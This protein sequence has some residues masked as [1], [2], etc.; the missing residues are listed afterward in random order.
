MIPRR[1]RPCLATLLALW[2]CLGF[3]A[4]Q[5][6]SVNDTARATSA[7]ERPRIGLVLS[8]GGARGLAHVGVLKVLEENHIPVDLV[9]GTSAG[10]IIGGLYA[11]G[12]SAREIEQVVL[13]V[14][15]NEGFSDASERQYRSFNRK[16]YDLSILT[17]LDVGIGLDGLR[18]PK[19]LLQGQRLEMLLKKV[20]APAELIEDFDRLPVPFR[21]V[22]TDIENGERVV[23]GHGSIVRAIHA[24]MAIPG[25][26]APVE[27]GGRMLV[28]GGLSSNLPVSTARELGANHIIAI[29]IST[30]LGSAEDLTSILSVAGQVSSLLTQRTVEQEISRLQADDT[31]ITPDLKGY[32]SGDF[33]KAA[34]IIAIGEQAARDSLERL[35]RYRIDARDYRA[36]RRNKPQL[37]PPSPIIDELVISTNSRIS[38]ARLASYIELKPGDRF[39]R[40]Q[41]E[42]DIANLYGLGYFS[43]ISYQ[44]DEEDG[45]TSLQ[46]D[47]RKKPWGPNYL[48]AGLALQGNLSGDNRVDIAAGLLATEVN[49]LG[50]EWRTDAT[51]GEHSGVETEFFQPLSANSNSFVAGTL[52]VQARNVRI[53]DDGIAI[54][55]A[56][57]KERIAEFDIGHQ[58]GNTTEIRLGVMRASGTAEV[59]TGLPVG[60]VESNEGAYQLS[61]RHDTMDNIHFPRKGD[62]AQLVF[63]LS[64]TQLGADDDNDLGSLSLYKP[65]T[66]GSHTLLARLAYSDTLDQEKASL[67]QLFQIGGFLNLS[68]YE[69]DELSGAYTGLM[70][71][72]YYRRFNEYFIKNAEIP[73]FIGISLEGGNA[74]LKRGDIGFDSM[75]VASSLF[76]GADTYIGPVY[77]GYGF[78]NEGRQTS[79][80]YIG[81]IF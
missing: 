56:R 33:D 37:T 45:Q 81:R 15:W 39:G 23:I 38:Q 76:L 55:T 66:W 32:S 28:D 61:I 42:K 75:V 77:V 2:A 68:G 21:A 71:L 35:S 31:L 12:L 51:F 79:Y 47:A 70:S 25:V 60:S 36:Y 34:A 43:H 1:P 54:F 57:L 26:Y 10:S 73:L 52:A 40:E 46:I 16:R 14:D 4:A 13:K 17:T 6:E 53:Y 8:G 69:Q 19:G 49:S 24:S 18:L 7:A 67:H 29:D 20:T 74:W 11:M 80:L 59:T 27:I 44:L 48:R 9:V 30:P 3:G 41:L 58:F 50:A 5:A 62:F 72:T 64:R 22:A 65:F 63:H 78:N